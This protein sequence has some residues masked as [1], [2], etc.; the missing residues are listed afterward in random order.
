MPVANPAGRLGQQRMA[1]QWMIM[2]DQR[3]GL[4]ADHIELVIGQQRRGGW[5]RDQQRNGIR[6]EPLEL[7]GAELFIRFTAADEDRVGRGV[8]EQHLPFGGSGDSQRRNAAQGWLVFRANVAQPHDGV[9]I[10]DGSGRES[11]DVGVGT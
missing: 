8:V 3:D 1:G 4:P 11:D 6:Y 5:M 2:T 10:V 7:F 9:S